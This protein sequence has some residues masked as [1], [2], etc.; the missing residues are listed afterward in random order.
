MMEAEKG[1]PLLPNVQNS[2][3]ANQT[4]KSSLGCQNLELRER[5]AGQVSAVSEA[6]FTLALKDNSLYGAKS[7]LSLEVSLNLECG[8]NSKWEIKHSSVKKV[9][10]VCPSGVG[11]TQVVFRPITPAKVFPP[12]PPQACVFKP[13][14]S[15]VWQPKIKVLSS[16]P[17]PVRETKLLGM[18]SACPRERPIQPSSCPPLRLLMS[19]MLVFS[20]LMRSMKP[21][22][23]YW[24]CLT[25]L[26]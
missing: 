17:F 21:R 3:K 14:P 15:L 23:S 6:E 8:P 16:R 11:P 19:P 4:I 20:T 18:S 10:C 9:D 25:R 2:N 12:N 26:T 13:K 22:M 24:R 1:K 7:P 5:C